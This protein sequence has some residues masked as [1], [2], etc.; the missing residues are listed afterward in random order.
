M[1]SD[2]PEPGTKRKKVRPAM[3]LA[4]AFMVL[5]LPTSAEQSVV[6]ATYRRLALKYHPD[7][8]AGDEFCLE[9]FKEL[10]T[11]YRVIEHK[12]RLDSTSPDMVHDECARCGEYAALRKGL[13]GSLCCAACLT[14]ANRR[15]LLPAPPLTIVTCATTIVLLVLAGGCLAAGWGFRN[16]TYLVA[17]LMIGVLALITLSITC[18]TVVYTADPKQLAR[19]QSIQ[20]IRSRQRARAVEHVD[21]LS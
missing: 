13:D 3:S 18:V 2:G 19:R 10:S 4:E 20:T 7:R 11:A 21:S 14:L 6:H 8:N 1:I 16:G 9:R 5:G 12:F 15:P 17:S